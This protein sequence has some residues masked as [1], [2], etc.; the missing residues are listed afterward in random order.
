MMHF[1]IITFARKL[2]WMLLSGGDKRTFKEPA[3]QL[4][5]YERIFVEAQVKPQFEPPG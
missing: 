2:S 5:K 1:K 3:T 4:P